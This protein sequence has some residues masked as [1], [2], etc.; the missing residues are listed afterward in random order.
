MEYNQKFIP[1]GWE[2]KIQAF[3]LEDLNNASKNGSIMEAKVTKCDSNYNLYLDL[4]NN[5]TG[6]IPREE[7][8]GISV[9]GTGFPKPNIC[10]S[11]VDKYVQF[12]VKDISK[13]DTVILSRKAVEKEAF[14]W[15]KNELKEGMQVL[16]IVKNIRP[17][18]AFIE[19]GGGVVGLV[20]IEDISVAR[21]KSPYERFK[22]GQKIKIVVK[23]IDRKTNR[24]IL[25]Y[26]EMLGTWEDNIKDFKEGITTKGI[27]R[28]TEK[29]K[30]G[31][32]IELKPNLIGLA[33]YKENIKYGDKVQVYIKRIIPE[34]KKIK[35]VIV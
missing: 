5:I 20:H 32:F 17:Y 23:S 16:G 21:I 24:V 26:K 34:K 28:E 25:S 31:I 15:V 10:I 13:K 8:E 33:D 9:D 35:L 29:S 4:G 14:T 11:K 3:S 27:V 6:I 7:I 30:N 1:E 2:S 18:G 22:I 19:I 12:K